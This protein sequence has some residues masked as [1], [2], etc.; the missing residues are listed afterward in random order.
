MILLPNSNP[1]I[2]NTLQKLISK[3]GA[4][5]KRDQVTV[6]IADFDGCQFCIQTS[7]DRNV[8][9]ISVQ[10]SLLKEAIMEQSGLTS[11]LK[12][13][14]GDLMTSPQ[15][16]YDL[17]LQF[18]LD[19]LPADSAEL[20]KKIAL[21]KRNILSVPFL[22]L[23]EN[24]S[25]GKKETNVVVIPYRS[26][27]AIYIKPD[28]DRAIVIFSIY[29]HDKDDIVYGKVFL[30]EFADAR[31][32]MNAAPSVNFSQ[33]EAPLE[34]KGTKGVTEGDDQGFVSFGLFKGHV[35][36]ARAQPTI[37]ILQMFRNYLHYHIKCS[38]AFMHT[39]MRNRVNTMLQ[40]LNRAKM[41]Q[42][43]EKKTA[44]GRTFNR[45]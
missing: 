2:E 8:V 3:A 11:R 1:I 12:A 43:E 24:V 36:G 21:L 18:N 45:T 15:S 28:A 35:A 10:W 23:F 20:P 34:I 33:K 4:S 16:G 7:K 30:Q 9:T 41:K 40:V 6:V 29:F 26:N 5:K 31:K 39:R 44:T 27:E 14:Y 32:T 22:Q 17:S 13:I 25:S 19:Q 38:K 42:K 37:D